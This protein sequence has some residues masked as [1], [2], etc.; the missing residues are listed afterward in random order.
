PSLA[1]LGQGDP[2]WTDGPT[3]RA[4]AF[5]GRETDAQ[6]APPFRPERTDTF[7]Y[8]GWVRPRGTEGGGAG[9][10]VVDDARR[11]RGF[12]LLLVKGKVEVHLVHEWPNDAVK[13]ISRVA[14]PPDAWSHVFVSYDGSGKAQGLKLFLDGRPLPV[15]VQANRLSGTTVND[16]PLR[17]GRRATG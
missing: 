3:G 7:S 12:D 14:V 11:F 10:S 8:G 1:Y 17:V 9:L 13:V 5:D 6:T 4:L 16:Q 2:S 15:D